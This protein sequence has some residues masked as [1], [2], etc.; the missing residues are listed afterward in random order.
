VRPF[1]PRLARYATGVRRLIALSVALGVASAVV[2]VVQAILL[3]GILADVIIGGAGPDQVAGRL[4]ALAVVIAIRAALAWAAEELAGRSASAVTAGLRRDLVLHA[5]ALGPRWRSGEHGGRLAVLATTGVESLHSYLAR[6]LPQLVLS[7]V[8]PGIMLI[9]LFSAD[10][11]SGIIVLVTLPLIPLFMALVG[12]Y[13][14]RQT[15]AKWAS[16]SRLAAHFTDVVAGLPTLKVFGRAKA[17]AEAVR[18]VTDDYR[19]SSMVTLR[20]A[21]LSSM[22]LEL[23]ASLSVALVAVAIGL[24]LVYGGLALEVGLAVLILAPEAYLPLRQLGT[25]FHAAADGV[26]AAGRV[27]DVLDT[28]PP[29]PGTRRDLTAPFGI[30]VDAATVG[31]AGERGAVGPLTLVAPA[32]QVTVVTGDSGAG[33]T[34]LL[35]LLAGVLRPDTGA[36]TVTS[37]T[38]GEGDAVPVADLDPGW[39]RSQLG[40]AAQ[41]GALQA[42]TIR[43]NL[44]LGRPDL[45][46]ATLRSALLAADAAGFVDALPGGLEHRL[47]DGGSGLSQGQ[48][49]RLTL[50][51]ALARPA[52]VLLLDEPT[53]ALDE[54]TEQRVL[55]GMRRLIGGR[56]VVLVTHRP[57]PLAL[58]D[59]IV[60]LEP[61]A[62]ASAEGASDPALATAAV[63]P[64]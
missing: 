11:T 57:G 46:E 5:A 17:Q 56:T 21:F 45:D 64:W 41:G 22:V 52:P 51:R 3:A 27:L 33:K 53:A 4:G 38:S 20:V 19:T 8:V 35:Q 34:T 44:T 42:G 32:G 40:W 29:V 26:E 37:G 36:V 18:R 30:R 48:R 7:V 54:P 24:R 49:Q 6:Y 62:G 63:N 12:W 15:R 31:R 9:Y 23:L 25:Q 14:D 28:P 16:L 1:D 10:L 55:A 60:R 13:T 58:A 39:W 2:V 47:G 43:Q 50:A 61:S 59:Q